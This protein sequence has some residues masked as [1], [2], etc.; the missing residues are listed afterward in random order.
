[1]RELG[2][3]QPEAPYRNTRK[4]NGVHDRALT[5]DHWVCFQRRW[6]KKQ[7]RCWMDLNTAQ[8]P[9]VD[10]LACNSTGC[11]HCS[12][13]SPARGAWL[14]PAYALFLDHKGTSSRH[15]NL[16]RQTNSDLFGAQPFRWLKVSF[17][18]S[19]FYSLQGNV[20]LSTLVYHFKYKMASQL[21]T[22][23]KCVHNSSA[24]LGIPTGK[25]P[26]WEPR[27][28]PYNTQARARLSQWHELHVGVTNTK[29]YLHIY[30]HMEGKKKEGKQAK[31]GKLCGRFTSHET[32][33]HFGTIVIS[34]PFHDITTWLEFNEQNGQKVISRQNKGGKKA[35]LRTRLERLSAKEAP[36]LYEC[37][38]AQGLCIRFPN[39]SEQWLH[40]YG[41]LTGW[42]SSGNTE[43]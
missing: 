17:R 13:F 24:T 40:T 27:P 30:T 34:R 39:C 41:H 37:T 14:Q 9:V 28:T 32:T 22:N 25:W 12:A 10:K 18:S 33:W 4:R 3:A 23:L 35:S 16:P 26:L 31:F 38:C 8:S 6:L 11:E 29:S 21:C 20:V 2:P 36:R 19:T 5:L 1:M 42:K 15:P 7:T 43:R